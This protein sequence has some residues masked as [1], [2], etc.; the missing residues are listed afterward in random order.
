MPDDVSVDAGDVV[1][2]KLSGVLRTS[3]SQED[4]ASR[5]REWLPPVTKGLAKEE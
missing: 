4:H 2:T 3:L 5:V 1:A